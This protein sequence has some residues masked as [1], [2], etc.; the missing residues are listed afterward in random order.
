MT[1]R[2]GFLFLVGVGAVALLTGWRF[3]PRFV[4]AAV[5]SSA[6]ETSSP[7]PEAENK[8]VVCYGYADLEEGI[9]FLHP[10]Q[11]GRVAR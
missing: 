5:T 11:P 2:S 3:L 10:S 4:P 6:G 8:L 7:A 1:Q 9:T